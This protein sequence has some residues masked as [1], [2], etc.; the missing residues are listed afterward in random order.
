MTHGSLFSG[1]GG[2]DLA[3]QWMGWDNAFHCEINPFSKRIL[4]YYWPSAS[5]FDDITKTDFSS[6]KGKIDV[7][8]GGFP[9]QPYS[10]A[11]D[12]KGKDDARHLWPQMLRVIREIEPEWIVGE[13]VLGI[14]NWNG[15][16]VFEE[17][18]TE[19]EAEGYSVQPFVLPACGVN[20]PHKRYRVWF[21]AHSNRSGRGGGVSGGR[22]IREREFLSG[23]FQGSSVGS[24]IEGRSGKRN[25][26]WTTNSAET[27]WQT[28]PNESPICSGNDGL[29]I[30]LDGIAFSTWRAESVKAY[31]NAIVPQVALQIFK[32][33]SNYKE[34]ETQCM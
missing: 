21:V 26:K 24:K 17:V 13:N 8:T 3:A 7:L 9:C 4:N 28:F 16:V 6:Y 2:F 14:T 29:S 22:S 25:D 15:G 19:L 34:R 5:S 18:C 10:S 33:I 20:A 27:N 30:E 31:G 12:R 32:T 23:E 1:I 11:G